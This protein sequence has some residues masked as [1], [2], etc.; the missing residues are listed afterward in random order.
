MMKAP[1]IADRRLRSSAVIACRRQ[2]LLQARFRL[3]EH[4]E[5]RRGVARLR[6]RRAGE[7]GKGGDANDAR[8][9][10]RN[11]LDLAH[12]L[13]GARQRRGARQL[14]GDDDVAAILRRNEALRRGRE[15]PAGAADQRDIDQQHHRRMPDHEIG[16]ARVAVRQPVEDAV[17]KAG[18]PVPA[19]GDEIPLRRRPLVLVRHQD[20]RGQRRRQ[21]QRAEAGDRGR[22][23]DGDGELLEELPGNAAEERG[24]HEHRAQHQRD[25]DQ[26]AADL[27]H[28]LERGVAPAHAVLEMPLDVF[29]HHD[30]V[31]DHDA[32]GEH[33]TEQRQIVDR[34][35][36]RRHHR[37]GADQRHRDRDDRNDR[38]PPALQEHQH[39]DDDE[40]HR[41]V[42][43][44]DQLMDGL[45]DE[46]GRVVA[47]IV[48]EPF[49]EARLEL[50][51]GV[52]RCSWR[53]PARSI[54]GA[55]SP[56][57]RPPISAGGSCWW[58]R[59]ARRARCA[60]RRAAVRCGRRCPP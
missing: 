35:A 18:E 53:S 9:I 25:R 33:E 19:A 28:G 21:R 48:V 26:R 30:G 8:R 42:D 57:S 38:G 6:A 60:R 3:V 31:V 40:R 23:R 20:Q 54:R 10:Q 15:Q 24:R 50:D 1:W 52:L 22:H 41:L 11:A 36:E 43:G 27:F 39:H 37:E 7:A 55:A 56:A 2:P 46:F 34:E 49:R 47:D 44:L 29:D 17:E 13:G 51:H 59:T 45:R 32:D 4:R 14:R 58:S 12:H 5:Q 16:R